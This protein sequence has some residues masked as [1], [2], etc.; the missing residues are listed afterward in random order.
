MND[1]TEESLP[2]SDLRLETYFKAHAEHEG[3][4]AMRERGLFVVSASSVGLAPLVEWPDAF[5]QGTRN[6]VLAI[7]AISLAATLV[8]SVF[9]M[10]ARSQL[11]R[12]AA[13]TTMSDRAE[14]GFPSSETVNAELDERRT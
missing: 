1:R 13:P 8:C 6:G 4:L 5:S 9:V 3:L 12:L 11:Q 14:P 10:R 2:P 7:W